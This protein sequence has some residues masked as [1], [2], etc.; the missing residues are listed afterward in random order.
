MINKNKNF[1]GKIAVSLACLLF[2]TGCASHMAQHNGVEQQTRNEVEMVKIP[3]NLQFGQ[4]QTEL[5][6]REIA[7]LNNFI[8]TAHIGYGDELSMDFPLDRNGELSEIDKARFEYLNNLL[9]NSG[10]H[11]SNSITPYGMEPPANSGRLLVSKYVVTTPEC[12][13]WSQR[14][15]PNHQNA[16]ISNFGC[17]NQANLGLMVAN[18]KD[19]IIGA[20]GAP[21]NSER[22]ALAV[23]RYQNK[24]VTVAPATAGGP[25]N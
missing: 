22:S 11:L 12:G 2:T 14:P 7:R 8:S 3:F 4:G 16:P 24:N 19:L 15:Y 6:G 9:K 20:T 18:P 23:E 25:S 1:S 21:T 10:L 5:S 13:D 17:A